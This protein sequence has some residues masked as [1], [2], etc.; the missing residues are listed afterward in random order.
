MFWVIVER[1]VLTTAGRATSLRTLNELELHEVSIVTFPM[2][3]TATISRV[4]Q[5]DF[6]RLVTAINRATA[7]LI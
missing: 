5:T 3:P 1:D 6:S 2:L 7:A 4:K